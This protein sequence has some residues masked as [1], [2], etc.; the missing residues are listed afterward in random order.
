MTF[1]KRKQ[2]RQKNLHNKRKRKDDIFFLILLKF[3]ILTIPFKMSFKLFCQ[4]PT[5][6]LTLTT[7]IVFL[8]FIF[9]VLSFNPL[10]G[11]K[12]RSV[13]FFIRKHFLFDFFSNF[14]ILNFFIFYFKK[15]FF[16]F[17][18]RDFSYVTIQHT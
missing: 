8:Q 12:V 6:A 11:W 4:H 1:L 16:S 18:P 13:L 10:F 3:N 14:F 9:I 7:W 15:N 5:I 17:K 2:F